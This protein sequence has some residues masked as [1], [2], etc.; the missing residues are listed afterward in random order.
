MDEPVAGTLYV[1]A[2]PL[3]NLGDMS[4][5]ARAILEKVDVIAAEDT[6]HG[7]RLLQHFGIRTPLLSV[8]EHNE[9]RMIAGILSRL[10]NEECVALIS[11]AGTP[12]ISDPGMRLV[13]EAHAH[14]ITVLPVP[15]PSALIAALSVAGFSADRFIF[16]G[17]L[18]PKSQARRQRL[19][20]LADETATLVF[21]EAPH[22]I[23]ECLEDL[24]Q[25][26]GEQRQA[27][28]ARELTKLYET[29]SRDTLAGLCGKIHQAPARGEFVLVIAGAPA[30]AEPEWDP[31]VT[32]I[33]HILLASLPLKQAA[34]LTSEITGVSR[35]S[36]YK[37]ALEHQAGESHN[38]NL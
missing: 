19:Q 24:R 32:R 18:P 34:R 13:A 22:R 12:L 26:F 31:D 6:R 20:H 33:L 21:Y 15:G 30:R 4:P 5:R 36:L 16:E 11:D 17:F 3:G 10:Q 1:V 35:N 7:G 37:L 8:H 38:K 29:V 2:T 27:V 9:R 23:I 28:L 25:V 14:G